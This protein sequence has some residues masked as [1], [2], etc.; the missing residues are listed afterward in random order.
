MWGFGVTMLGII[1]GK[2]PFFRG[3]DDFDMAAKIVGLLGRTDFDAY[4]RKYGITLPDPLLRA[5]PKNGPRKDLHTLVS[6]SSRSL[7]SDEAIDL[8]DKCLR[9]DHVERLTAEQALA[10]PYFN[11][12]RGL[13]LP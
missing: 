11:Q 7:V 1:F 3:S 13:K 4:I 12:V 6:K 9:Y 2:T 8:I 10:H 5:L